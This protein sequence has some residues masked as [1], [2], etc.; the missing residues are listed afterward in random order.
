MRFNLH[1]H[2]PRC[3]HA[4]GSEEEFVRVA[5]ENHYDTLGFADHG[6]WPFEDGFVS[7]IRM[8]VGELAGYVQAVRK[9]GEAHAGQIRVLCG[10]E[11]EYFPAY[12]PWLRETREALGLDYLI[13]GNHF[14]GKE[15]GGFYFGNCA[16]P[17]QR[18]QYLQQTIAGMETGLFAY[19]AHPDLFLRRAQPFDESCVQDSR[20]LCRAAKALGL[21]LEYNLLGLRYQARDAGK[22]PG[23]GYPCEPFWE[24]AAEEDCAAIL[25]VDAHH[26]VH[27]QDP[28]LYD[29]A[30]LHLK[31]LGL[32][33]LEASPIG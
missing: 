15:N 6:P 2:T 22:Y 19:V 33:R 4:S 28:E 12:M 25:G 27:L 8:D 30:A 13:L 16:T 11:Y 26:V 23:L 21:P 1:T 29:L 9:A 20:T 3:K 7:R 14:D 32:R 10:L 18:A 24:V 31:T 17:A 5:I